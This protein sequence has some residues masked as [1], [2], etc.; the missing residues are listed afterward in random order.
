MNKQTIKS[1]IVI[2]IVII[3][4]T[5]YIANYKKIIKFFILIVGDNID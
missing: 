3:S 4:N 2:I 1:Y 5:L